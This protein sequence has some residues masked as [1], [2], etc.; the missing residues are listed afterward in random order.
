[1][2]VYSSYYGSGSSKAPINT[3]LWAFAYDIDDNTNR[4][5]LK[6]AP[7]LGEIVPSKKTAYYNTKFFPYKKNSKE[8]KTSVSV[9]AGSRMYADTYDEAIEAYNKLIQKRIDHLNNMI[10]EAKKDM[11]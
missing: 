6:C 1:M 8:L 5:S 9:L 4:A 2:A 11:I 7:V 3:P 10:A